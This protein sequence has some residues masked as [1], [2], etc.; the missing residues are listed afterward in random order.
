MISLH[1]ISGNGFVTERIKELPAEPLWAQYNFLR[2]NLCVFANPKKGVLKGEYT[3]VVHGHGHETNGYGH[4]TNGHSHET[5]GHGHQTNG[6]GHQT[7]GHGHELIAATTSVKYFPIVS[8]NPGSFV[9]LRP[10]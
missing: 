8:K 9:Y 10:L 4:E 2:K 5:N 3:S 1:L 7:N 6:H